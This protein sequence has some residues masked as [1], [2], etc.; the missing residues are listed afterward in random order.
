[1]QNE[2]EV[3]KD[4]ESDEELNRSVSDYMSC[5]EET[6]NISPQLQPSDSTPPRNDKKAESQLLSTQ[7]TDSSQSQSQWEDDPIGE[8]NKLEQGPVDKLI[9]EEY[10]RN[11][12]NNGNS[13]STYKNEDKPESKNSISQNQLDSSTSTDDE[14]A[15]APRENSIRSS[16]GKQNSP[17]RFLKSNS[18]KKSAPSSGNEQ[19]KP[20]GGR[21]VCTALNEVPRLLEVGESFSTLASGPTCIAVGTSLG[22]VHLLTIEGLFIACYHPPSPG[23]VVTHV[24]IGNDIVVVA[25]S[26]GSIRYWEWKTGNE[27]NHTILPPRPVFSLA[28]SPDFSWTSGTLYVSQQ[29]GLLSKRCR[30]SVSRFV[31]TLI[32]EETDT[33]A[34]FD[35]LF[36][37]LPSDQVDKE[38][39]W[40]FHPAILSNLIC[41]FEFVYF[42]WKEH[43]FA[44]S[45]ER[46][47]IVAKF[48][49]FPPFRPD[50]S[51]SQIG[52]LLG[53]DWL[54][55]NW[56]GT[57][58]MC[59]RRNFAQHP[60]RVVWHY[61]VNENIQRISLVADQLVL[62]LSKTITV[63][64]EPI[65]DK[66]R[67]WQLEPNFDTLSD[68]EE[69]GP[70]FD[71]TA[72]EV[73]IFKIEKP[74]QTDAFRLPHLSGP[75]I[76]APY[77]QCQAEGAYSGGATYNATHCFLLCP[78]RLY[79]LRVLKASE[80]ILWLI[81]QR[82]Y[83]QAMH[84]CQ[85]TYKRETVFM[86]V[87]NLHAENLWH[88]G[89]HE[90]S[91][92][93]WGEVVLPS[94]PAEY[95]KLFVDRLNR[96]DK[97]N[98]IVKWLPFNDR[99]KVT[100]DIYEK[101][102]TSALHGKKFLSL[103]ARISR[104][105]VL[106][107]TTA[108]QNTIL[109]Q[110]A[111]FRFTIG[112]AKDNISCAE[113][114]AY[115]LLCS[116]FKLYEF[117]HMF[118]EALQVLLLLEQMKPVAVQVP[119]ENDLDDA[120]YVKALQKTLDTLE[121]TRATDYFVTR[122]LFRI[123]T[124]KIS[125]EEA[126]PDFMPS[127]SPRASTDGNHTL[128]IRSKL[129]KAQTGRNQEAPNVIEVLQSF[130][131]LL[132]EEEF[133]SKLILSREEL[134]NS[135]K[136]RCLLLSCLMAL[137]EN[138]VISALTD[139]KQEVMLC[140][141]ATMLED[142]FGGKWLKPFLRACIYANVTLCEHHQR[143]FVSD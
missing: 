51:K 29:A 61:P 23:V 45:E 81:Q 143:L 44:Y 110:L 66:T 9:N 62:C 121:R 48:G 27:M 137:D 16:L 69:E 82:R 131:P 22:R 124:T 3:Q 95:W 6:G 63:E 24:C 43:V 128:K 117:G 104:W 58:I 98:L 116:L 70:K 55:I 113:V 10:H 127:W 83:P 59:D 86:E 132:M 65:V 17:F 93:V 12:T 108:I 5:G 91:V 11:D 78:R 111:S 75:V 39:T 76:R 53:G 141:V 37:G 115:L 4:S 13:G 42:T 122:R 41:D 68:V 134:F 20:R 64:E 125:P 94:A 52:L 7:P 25:T 97:L 138:M 140:E 31:D 77:A 26:D 85:R 47:R 40:E 36:H 56:G 79:C 14:D 30:T 49:R 71:M 136:R 99:T 2:D 1:M 38:F 129:P 80:Q 33:R 139:N 118:A 54:V 107:R 32:F 72:S 126:F 74:E 57:V 112:C 142:I 21:Y 35:R 50:G 89:R 120:S 100:P 73:L 87:A 109:R 102:L 19:S 34:E 90:E 67:R 123:I 84:L 8:E 96:A 28:I 105:P 135:P 101:L 88:Q 60:F 130:T 106:Y 103:L 15:N 92:R 46:D 18:L 114:E 133:K 119:V